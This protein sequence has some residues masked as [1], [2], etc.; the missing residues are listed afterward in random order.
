MK[1]IKSNTQVRAQ[2]EAGPFCMRMKTN[3][4]CCCREEGGRR[5]EGRKKKEEGHGEKTSTELFLHLICNLT[6]RVLILSEMYFEWY[7]FIT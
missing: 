1:S 5:E 3:M 6:L 2:K 7:C 4:T